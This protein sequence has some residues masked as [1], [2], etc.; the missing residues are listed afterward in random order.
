M[1][2]YALLAFN[3]YPFG[4]ELPVETTEKPLPI[5]VEGPPS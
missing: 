1:G 4:A 2:C 3:L 5:L